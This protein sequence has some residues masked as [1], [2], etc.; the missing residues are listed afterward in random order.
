M[1][2]INFPITSNDTGYRKSSGKGL[3]FLSEKMGIPLEEM[4]FIGDEKKDMDCALNAGATAVLIN[5]TAEPKS[6]GQN[7]EIR[8]LT[9]ITELFHE[10]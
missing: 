9:G 3:C 4:V 10:R 5:R 2:Y 8:D 6:F 7:Y 1:K